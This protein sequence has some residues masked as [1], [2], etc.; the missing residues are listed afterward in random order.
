MKI[1]KITRNKYSG[2]V[3]NIGVPTNHNYFSNGMLVHN[4]YQGST[5]NGNHAK[6]DKIETIIR[7]LSDNEVF[8]IAYG[9][10]EPTS[11]PDFIKI[12]KYTREHHIIPNFTTRNIKWLHEH[13]GEIADIIGS[14]AYSVDSQHKIREL[15]TICDF[16][17]VSHHKVC[18][19]YVLGANHISALRY[20]IE[21]CSEYR[22]SLTLLGFKQQER[23]A[24]FRQHNYDEW[25]D[26]VTKSIEDKYYCKIGIDTALAS[27]YKTLLEERVPKWLYHTD[28]GRFSWYIDAVNNK[29][30]PSS[31]HTL[32]PY[33]NMYNDFIEQYHK[34][35]NT[36]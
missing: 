17:D 22:F 16:Y 28:E 10:G 34:Y 14:F 23:G 21:Q 31:Y 20:I 25:F 7:T 8:E 9:G 18:I 26:I 1:S 24:N 6:L 12:L 33:S 15:A 35:N 4:C 29:M 32:T 2:K 30:G 3:Y 11:H 27:Q 13:L 5:T 19:Q 36:L